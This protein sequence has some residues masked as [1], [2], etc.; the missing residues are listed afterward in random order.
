MIELLAPAGNYEC[1][2]AAVQNG[3]DAVYFAGE[4]Y[5]ARSYA[6]NFDY[7]TL[8][9]AVDYCRLRGVKS[10]IT[11]NTLCTDRELIK[12]AQYIAFLAKIGV[13]A[14]IVQDLGVFN[15]IKQVCP[16]MP[17]HASTQMTVHNLDGVLTLQKMGAQ[18]VVLSRELSLE[19]I[20]NISENSD[21]ELEV[22]AHGALCMC[23]SGQCL[24][25]SVFGGRS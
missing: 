24:M 1:I 14:V 17:I 9:K 11:V 20:K 6:D 25:S 18:R 13:D 3:A 12:C 2:V 8:E 19:N 16:Q 5:G 22:F 15:M 21:I 4:N 23:Y 7:K 10:H